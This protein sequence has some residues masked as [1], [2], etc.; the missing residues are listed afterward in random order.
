MDGTVNVGVVGT[1]WWSD[2]WHVPYLCSHP[3]AELRAVCD[4][5]RARAEEVAAKH[6]IP[7]VFTDFREMIR[8]SKVE[9]IV[10]AVPDDLHY[11]VTMA[12]LDAGLHVMC[13]KPLAVTVKDARAMCEK[14]ES[15]GVTHMTNFTYRWMPWYRYVREQIQIGAIGRCYH[16]SI[17]YLGSYGR[18]KTYAWRFDRA[19]GCGVLGDLG[20][21][22]IDLSRWFRATSR[23]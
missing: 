22:M 11:A 3:R 19:H 17:R 9:A 13:E 5:N 21:H 23:G 14:A 15:A 8:S 7:R 10:V 1:S 16:C 20:S 12:A 2:F 6:S 4:R 18:G